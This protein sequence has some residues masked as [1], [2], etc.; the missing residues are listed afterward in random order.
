MSHTVLTCPRHPDSPD[1]MLAQ[2]PSVLL[3][4]FTHGFMCI[5]KSAPALKN[6]P[7]MYALVSSG[8]PCSGFL[9][10]FPVCRSLLPRDCILE[11]PFPG[12]IKSTLYGLTLSMSEMQFILHP[13][14]FLR[15]GSVHTLQK[16]LWDCCHWLLSVPH[17]LILA[18]LGR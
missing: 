4:R 17:D 12:S 11:A 9:S 10:L 3:P 6:P 7:Y 13:L 15:K 16:L 18:I 14:S 2:F 8:L 5:W 1:T